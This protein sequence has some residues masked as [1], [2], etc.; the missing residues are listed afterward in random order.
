MA[1]GGSDIEV[2]P[3]DPAF[4]PE[5]L[6]L[7]RT[8]FKEHRTGNPTAFSPKLARKI[9]RTHRKAISG[10][11]KGVETFAAVRHGNLL[12]YVLIKR[13]MGIALIYD[14]CVA[15]DARR[16]GLGTR[17]LERAVS[18]AKD[19]ACEKLFAAVWD[20]NEPS[21]RLFRKSGFTQSKPVFGRFSRLFP[22]L[23]NASY[24]LTLKD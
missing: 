16:E 2:A 18:Q 5:I 22:R 4:L 15:P 3:A 6:S 17:L 10:T 14:I 23:R 9:E 11:A 12:G 20:G 24:Q 13:R 7:A 19:H 21:H 1:G 8:T